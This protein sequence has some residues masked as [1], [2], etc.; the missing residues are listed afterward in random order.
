[1]EKRGLLLL[2]ATPIGNLKDISIRAIEALKNA[3]IIAAEDTRHSGKLLKAYD[4]HT[5]MISLHKFNESQKRDFLLKLLQNGNNIAL[6]SDAGT[7][8]ICDPGED[9]VKACIKEN[10]SVSIVPGANA[11][12]SAL[13]ISGN[14]SSSFTFHGFVPKKK[15]EK[16]ELFSSLIYSHHTNIFYESPH[17]IKD[18]LLVLKTLMPNRLI[19]FVRE[20]TKLHEEVLRGM[21]QT[22]LEIYE[23]KEPKG[24]YVLIIE[25]YHKCADTQTEMDLENAVNLV[26]VYIKQ[27]M[28]KTQAIKK[29]CGNTTLDRKTLYDR[30]KND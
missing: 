24:E 13:A 28:K 21:A 2:V 25:A 1:M 9:I 7:P 12:I 15:K 20:L 17:R 10:I 19:T 26:N 5:K 29:V 18:T 6:I 16:E 23:T 27:G 3:D 4:I 11:F 8:G 22:L 30:L 14:T